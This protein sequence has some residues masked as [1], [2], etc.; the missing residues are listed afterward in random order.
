MPSSK[1]ADITVLFPKEGESWSAFRKRIEREQGSMVIV[2][3][4]PDVVLAKQEKE[5]VIFL[6][7]MAGLSSRVHLATRQRVLMAAARSRGIRVV[8]S[9]QD[10]KH[11]LHGHPKYEEA[12]RAFSPNIWRQKL[13]SNLQSMGL[14]S[15]PKLRVWI[16]ILVSGLLF[17]FVIFR[18]L[19]SATIQVWPR[20]DTISQT[21]NI[22]LV[23]S[24]STIEEVPSRVR[25]LELMP[26]RVDV[27]RSMTFDQISK[28]FVGTSSR[29]AMTMINTAKETYSLRVGTRVMNQAGMVFRTQE[30]AVIPPGGEVTVRAEADDM[31]LYGEIVGERGNVPAGLHWNIPGL[32]K[33]EQQKVYAE[34][35]SAGFGGE[36]AYKTVVHEEDLQVAKLKLEQELLSTAKQLIDEQRE[37]YNSEHP[38]HNMEIL[39]YDELT[40]SSYQNFSLPRQFL[41]QPMLSVPVSGE[42]VYTAYAY[43][44][45]RILELLKQELRV[46]TEEGKRLLEDTLTLD[47]LVAHVID[48]NDELTWIKLTV[49]LSGTVQYI[50]DP[51]SPTGAQFGKKLRELI[52]GKQK[53]TAERIIQNL[54]EVEN[55]EIA[56]WPPWQNILPS[57]PSHIS[58]DVMR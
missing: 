18:L 2:L 32:S 6:D 23:L 39:Y 45:H 38:D 40:N 22:F 13:R 43:D 53:V 52:T 27:E 12:V 58:I 51:L 48:Y 31:D 3:T 36:S 57:I 7:A 1:N 55:V 29:V 47:R 41:G 30:P 17:L 42:I 9:V 20:E 44:S 49:D 46:H 15:L 34:N 11:L 19:P 26:I 33:E 35:R 54:P 10:L 5:R 24:G 16:L 50:L 14:L 8:D 25:T 37:L 21:A 28:E 56:V 4:G